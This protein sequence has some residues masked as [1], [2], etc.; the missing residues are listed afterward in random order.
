MRERRREMA[1][2]RAQQSYMA[3]KASRQKKIKS[4]K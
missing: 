2:L 4:K 3:S 1:K